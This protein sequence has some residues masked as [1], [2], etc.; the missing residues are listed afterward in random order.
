[1]RS[2]IILHLNFPPNGR[3]RADYI[4][5]AT[6]RHKARWLI[7][8]VDLRH[9]SLRRVALTPSGGGHSLSGDSFGIRS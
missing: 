5:F 6:G 4:I 9:V 2:R 1:M 7:Q 8:T 3:L